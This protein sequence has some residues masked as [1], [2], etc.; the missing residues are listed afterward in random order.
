MT[1]I[2]LGLSFESLLELSGWR[3]GKRQLGIA[4]SKTRRHPRIWVKSLRRR[5]GGGN[6]VSPMLGAREP[7]EVLEQQSGLVD[8]V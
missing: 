8:L 5:W 1:A 4:C 3:R 7:L 2:G 6:G